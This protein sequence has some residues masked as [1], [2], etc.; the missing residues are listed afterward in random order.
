MSFSSP[1]REIYLAD[2]AYLM[3]LQCYRGSILKLST[4]FLHCHEKKIKECLVELDSD[5]N[6]EKVNYDT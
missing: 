1:K 2:E 6:R 4:L 5:I 3:V